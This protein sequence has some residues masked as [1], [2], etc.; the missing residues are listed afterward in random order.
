MGTA[1]A[2]MVKVERYRVRVG[3]KRTGEVDALDATRLLTP[4]TAFAQPIGWWP[5]GGQ[6][7]AKWWREEYT[8]KKD[9]R[10]RMTQVPCFV[11]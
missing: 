2:A 5:S 11:G 6:M 9:L 1:W 8:R 10:Q 4:K 7:V 3:I